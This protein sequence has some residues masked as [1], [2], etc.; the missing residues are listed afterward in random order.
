MYISYW[1]CFSLKN[2]IKEEWKEGRKEREDGREERKEKI[3]LTLDFEAILVLLCF[4][5]QIP[6]TLPNLE[7]KSC[8]SNT[9][10]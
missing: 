6:R 5:V 7:N 3:N 8:L 4:K 9:E 1:F 2:L 10:Q